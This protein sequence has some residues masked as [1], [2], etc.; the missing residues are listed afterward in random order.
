MM[1]WA[2]RRLRKT[3]FW[4]PLWDDAIDAP[5]PIASSPDERGQL[6]EPTLFAFSGPVAHIGQGSGLIYDVTQ[7]EP[8]G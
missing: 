8:A 5:D 3:E 6:H 7:Q 1:P 2:G 4:P